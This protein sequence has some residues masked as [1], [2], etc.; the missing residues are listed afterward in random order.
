[1]LTKVCQWQFIIICVFIGAC[2]QGHL[3]RNLF[4]LGSYLERFQLKMLGKAAKIFI[5]RHHLLIE[6]NSQ[7]SDDISLECPQ[8]D[9][10]NLSSPTILTSVS[11]MFSYADDLNWQIFIIVIID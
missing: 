2:F 6:V 9:L 4:Q 8:W 3:R 11:T 1:M 7:L 5:I 10:T